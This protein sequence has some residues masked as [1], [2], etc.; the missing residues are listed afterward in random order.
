M[1]REPTPPEQGRATAALVTRARAIRLGLTVKILGITGASIALVALILATSFGSEVEKLLQDELTTRGRM[2]ALSLANTSTTLLFAQDV[3]GLQA[4]ASATLQDVPGAAYVLVRDERGEVL[5]EA[6]EEALGPARPKAVPLAELDL[7]SRFL[8]RKVAVGERQMLHAVALVSFK[9]KADVQY[10]DPLGLNPGAGAGSAALKVLGSVEI[11]FPLAH[12]TAQIAAA[13]RRSVGLAAVVFA[14][15][16]LVM[17]PLARLTTRPLAELS[18]AALG[19]AGGDLRQEVKRDGNDEVADLARSFARMISELQSM[20]AEL[21]E[22]AGALAQESDA[23]LAAATR[24]AAMAAQQSASVAEM[25][26][27]IREI[28]QTSSVATEHADRVIVVTQTAEESSRAGEGIVEEAVGSTAHVEEHVTTI[29]SR[30]GDLSSRASQIGDI[31][32]TVKDLASRSNVLALNAAIQASRSGEASAGFSVIAREMRALAEQSSGTAGEVPKLLGEIVESA[33][34]AATATQQGTEKARSTAALARR[35]GATIGNLTSVCRES[36]AA[37]RHIADSSRQQ[38]TGVNEV[39][40]ALAQLARA[41][42]G[43]VEGSEEM[44]RVAERLKTVSGRLTHLAERY[45][46]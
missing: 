33:Q 12:L 43:N 25:N 17:L 30:L 36:A 23:M 5:A 26:A 8:E 37:A 34:S 6:V 11:G 42:E 24:Q 46:S 4:L 31:I 10:L 39:V 32:A 16:L 44:R 19:V 27:S 41:A 21:K 45:R 3:S 9:G 35:A 29:A 13:S 1:S 2:A 38:A 14:A 15:C 7:G 28:A 22:A 18:R 20:L 40:T